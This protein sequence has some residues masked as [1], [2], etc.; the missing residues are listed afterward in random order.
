AALTI[1]TLFRG[2][3][4]E[5]ILTRRTI[6][7][8]LVLSQVLVFRDISMRVRRRFPNTESLVIAGFLHE[9]ER[10]ELESISIN[11]NKYWAPIN[12]ALTLCF[13]AHK[14]GHINAAPSLNACVLVSTSSP[15]LYCGPHLGK[16]DEEMDKSRTDSV[17][18]TVE[19]VDENEIPELFRK[20]LNGSTKSNQNGVNGE[21]K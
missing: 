21:P 2:D 19:S 16:V 13:K 17:K 6:I 10:R 15:Q 1:A 7:R 11:Y 3:T 9:H 5:I 14:D 4:H 20:E 8:Y 18:S 12:W